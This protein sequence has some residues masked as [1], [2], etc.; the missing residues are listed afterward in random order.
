MPDKKQKTYT[1]SVYNNK[2]GKRIRRV[3][4]SKTFN[5]IIVN[6]LSLSLTNI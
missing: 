4:S 6:E 2:A 3:K 5:Y 1:N